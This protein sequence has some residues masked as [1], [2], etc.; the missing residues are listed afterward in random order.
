MADYDDVTRVWRYVD[1]SPRELRLLLRASEEAA[2]VLGLNFEILLND[3]R[4][5]E[6]AL[7]YWKLA[8]KLRKEGVT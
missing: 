8:L 5:P 7:E 1:F 6:D 2:R 4:Q 3:P